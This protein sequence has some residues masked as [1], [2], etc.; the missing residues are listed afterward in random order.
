[1]V[2][3]VES[4]RFYSPD[5]FAPPVPANHNLGKIS[6]RPPVLTPDKPRLAFDAQLEMNAAKRLTPEQFWH[7]EKRMLS[8]YIK[9]HVI[10]KERDSY[11]YD[12]VRNSQGDI[13]KWTAQ[14]FEDAPDI[15][16][17]FDRASGR[18]A[19]AEKEGFRKIR[20]KFTPKEAAGSYFVIVSP[21]GLPEEGFP[22]HNFIGVGKVGQ[23]SVEMVIERNWLSTSELAQVVNKFLP[24]NERLSDESLDTDFIKTL[25]AL[26]KELFSSHED[27][28]RL[29]S[30][31]QVRDSTNGELF[32]ELESYQERAIWA[33]WSGNRDLVVETLNAHENFARAFLNGENLRDYGHYGSYAPPMSL[34]SCGLGGRFMSG[35][36]GGWNLFMPGWGLGAK[37]QTEGY[38]CIQ[39]GA[40][41]AYINCDVRPGE[42]CPKGCGAVRQCV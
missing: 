42:S 11:S 30:D 15:S 39:C 18:R 38:F 3:T 8:G 4:P 21:P 29:F 7:R 13:V 41:G 36:L 1:M 40:C 34:E 27:I 9:E 31:R 20:Q 35:A 19:D 26:P 5:V 12:L 32:K 37:K 16:D 14:G 23:D 2:N 33:M 17:V 24:D 28:L 10:K 22:G 6:Q 25:V